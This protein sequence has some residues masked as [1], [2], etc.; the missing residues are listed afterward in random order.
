MAVDGR[1]CAC[2]VWMQSGPRP[3]FGEREGLDRG[4]V[5]SVSAAMT[6]G[7]G[8][9]A[10]RGEWKKRKTRG[11]G[12][13]L[14]AGQEACLPRHTSVPMA[15]R[16]PT[17]PRSQAARRVAAP[18]WRRPARR[19]RRRASRICLRTPSPSRRPACA[20]DRSSPRR[21]CVR[22]PWANRLAG[23]MKLLLLEVRPVRAGLFFFSFSLCQYAQIAAFCYI[24]CWPKKKANKNL[25]W[26][27]PRQRVALTPRGG[28]AWS[29]CGGVVCVVQRPPPPPA[30]RVCRRSLDPVSLFSVHRATTLTRSIQRTFSFYP[31]TASHPPQHIPL[32]RTF[33]RHPA[34]GLDPY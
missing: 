21:S 2:C 31:P 34:R 4:G 13:A 11:A 32:L 27:R 1:G 23:R 18:A 26:P 15:G 9:G 6:R 33:R 8:R 14:R 20:R 29:A 3:P 22:W 5:R 28:V 17:H 19:P 16:P 12:V 24:F 30:D 10:N 7:E 25:A